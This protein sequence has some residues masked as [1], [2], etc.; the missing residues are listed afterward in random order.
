MIAAGTA[1]TLQYKTPLF[2]YV[3]LFGIWSQV[4]CLV[5]MAFTPDLREAF[6]TGVPLLIA[7]MVWYKL[8]AKR[9]A[10]LAR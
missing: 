5:I 8:R 3:T 2:P 4:I 6:F 7:P 1:D 10:A 9:R